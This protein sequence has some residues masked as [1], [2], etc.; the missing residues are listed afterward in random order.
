[1]RDPGSDS[2]S[3]A[4]GGRTLGLCLL[5]FAGAVAALAAGSWHYR[6]FM[7]DDAFISLRYADR[8]LHGAGLTW[9]DGE[10]VEGYTNLLWVLGCAFLGW[11]GLDLVWAARLL[12]VA[13]TAGAI[14][15]IIWV[16]RART[17]R[18]A[19]P[20]ITGGLAV[21]MS[22][23]LVVWTFGGLEQPLLAGLLAWA[24]AFSFPLLD[25]ARPPAS[26]I[27]LPGLF[28]G[29]IA[30][31]RADGA[32]FT[33]AAFLGILA[34][35]GINRESLRIGSTLIVL[36]L[37]FFAGQLA[38]RQAT[39][40]EWLP[41]SA[42]AK[43]GFT[44]VRLAAGLHYVAGA[45]TLAGILAPAILALRGAEPGPLR[46]RIRLLATM[47][48][49]WLTYLVIVGGDL[50]P[51]RRHLVP[52]V[53]PLV[54]LAAIYL[55]RKIPS[56]GSLRPALGASAL[57]LSALMLFQI[58]DPMNV[59]AK[60]ERWEWDGEAVGGLLSKAFGAQR[61][62]LAV[63]PAGCVP[64]F[65]RLPS[66][67]ML[68]INDHYL[69][70]HRPADFGTGALGHEL[71]DGPYVLSRK[72]DLVLFNLPTGGRRPRLRSGIEMMSDPRAEFTSTFRAVTIECEQPR[73]VVSVI[74]MRT[75][76]GAIGIKRSEDRIQIP[77]YLFSD[78]RRSRSRL[79]P[80]G[81]LGVA[82]LPG[83]PAEFSGLRVPPGTWAVRVESSGGV[84]STFIEGAD[85][86]G[87]ST[88]EKT[89]SSFR[90]AGSA[91]T[92]LT[93]SL[94]T[95]QGSG[96]HVRVVVLQRAASDDSLGGVSPKLPAD[97]G[98]AGR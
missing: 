93:I 22:G 85:M 8:L 62:L 56:Q 16:Y 41:N 14:A 55:A 71:G 47:L 89:G 81:R 3:R 63:D 88:S 69:A 54:Y 2:P 13:G 49:V 1:M 84:V 74:W 42:F 11:L 36:P 52:A 33:F 91:S 32:L 72:P 35:R 18:G 59:L 73:P 79:D 30:L 9:N 68:G 80:E 94:W 67:D 98:D 29:L 6:Q 53:I 12:G 48:I 57:C 76:G 65:S 70:H 90:I 95:E 23:P 46:N 97:I 24:L 27:V 39:Y 44:S 21:A 60:H 96:A 51:G 4:R 45:I 77:G 7:A 92:N 26:A 43:V 19:L 34:A 82:V 17:V 86:G 20:G 66:I 78:N 38:F 50:F 10:M 83:E 87:V 25:D 58:F 15:A 31:T 61:P 28:F 64:Y 37:L 40:H 75:E 5:A